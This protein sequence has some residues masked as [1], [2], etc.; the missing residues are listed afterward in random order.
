LFNRSEGFGA[1]I[2]VDLRGRRVLIDRRNFSRHRPWVLF[3]LA[4]T[5][6]SCAWYFTASL[7]RSQWPGGS[8][9][10]GLVFGAVGG[11]LILFEF[12]LWGRKK[13]RAWRIG[14]V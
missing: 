8:S 9:P 1:R 11:L 13:V 6:L 14:R 10:P 7:G 2:D 12:A 3:L 4:A 5:A